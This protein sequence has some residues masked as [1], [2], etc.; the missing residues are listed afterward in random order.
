MRVFN[1]LVFSAFIALGT[2]SPASAEAMFMGLGD[3]PGGEFS[4]AARAVSADGSVVVGFG[5]DGDA[6]DGEKAF[7]WEN[8]VMTP[9]DGPLAKFQAVATAGPRTSP[10][11][12]RSSSAGT[13][14]IKHPPVASDPAPGS[15]PFHSTGRTAS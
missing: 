2:A 3:L 12:A 1:V 4:S 13:D 14:R 8:G 10:Q 7:R 15:R 11:T 6:K 5:D 9:L